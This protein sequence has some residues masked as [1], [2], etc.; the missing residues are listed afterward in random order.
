[1]RVALKGVSAS[2]LLAAHGGGSGGGHTW[3][4]RDYEIRAALL[5]LL[6]QQAKP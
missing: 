1:M 6:I 5:H 3:V 2:T 4:G